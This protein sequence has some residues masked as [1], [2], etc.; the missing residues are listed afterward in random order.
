MNLEQQVEEI[1]RQ[2]AAI[3]DETCLLAMR[4]GGFDHPETM[5]KAGYRIVRE[6]HGDGEAYYVLCKDVHRERIPK[7][8]FAS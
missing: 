3:E 8:V 4:V 1:A 5:R 7:L 2:R 6:Q